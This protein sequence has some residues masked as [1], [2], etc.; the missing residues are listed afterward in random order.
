[1]TQKKE[2]PT[3]G[4]KVMPV[5]VPLGFG[6]PVLYLCQNGHKSEGHERIYTSL[7]HWIHTPLRAVEK[8]YHWDD[9]LSKEFINL[10]N[11]KLKNWPLI[12]RD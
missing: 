5:D 2:C 11:S 10:A 7:N 6:H 9:E 3:C 12:Y 1:M 8:W 4:A